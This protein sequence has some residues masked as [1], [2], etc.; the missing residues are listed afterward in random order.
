MD[1]V[2]PDSVRKI[3]RIAASAGTVVADDSAKPGGVQVSSPPREVM[4]LA[5]ADARTAYDDLLVA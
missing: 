2:A 5:V 4:E 1:R 3:G